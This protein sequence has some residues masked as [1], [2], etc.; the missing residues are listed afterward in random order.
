MRVNDP[1]TREIRF[2]QHFYHTCTVVCKGQGPPFNHFF[3][4]AD[5]QNKINNLEK[6][7]KWG[8]KNKQNN[9]G[10]T[11]Y[12]F[13][14]YI[15]LKWVNCVHMP[16]KA[17]LKCTNTSTVLKKAIVA[18]HPSGKRYRIIVKLFEVKQIIHRWKE[19]KTNAKLSTR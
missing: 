13:I 18:A 16:I 5:R 11:K 7:P 3:F 9:M 19:F 2:C 8:K 6:K 17:E 10:N 12:P 4:L 15:G 14:A 1:S